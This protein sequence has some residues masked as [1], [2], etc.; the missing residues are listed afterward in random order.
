MN[1]YLTCSESNSLGRSEFY[2]E[3]DH[4]LIYRWNDG[5]IDRIMDMIIRIIDGY[6][7]C[8]ESNSVGRS[9]FGSNLFT[10]QI[11]ISATRPK[12]GCRKFS[13]QYFYTNTMN[14]KLFSTR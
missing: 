6:L 4:R 5:W 14:R 1:R 2:N 10:N 11:I 13:K 12:L 8:S 7:T 3:I 9:A